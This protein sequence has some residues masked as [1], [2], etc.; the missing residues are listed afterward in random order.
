MIIR[1]RFAP[2]PTGMLHIGGLRTAIFNWLLAKKHQ[3]IFYLRVEDTD[4][5][6]S[7]TKYLDSIKSGLHWLG[8]DWNQDVIFQS[9]NIQRH[10]QI[11]DILLKQGKAYYCYTTEEERKNFKQKNPK[12]KFMSKWR[13]ENFC[14]KNI[15]AVVR[16]KTENDG[17]TTL[18]DQVIGKV[19]IKNSELDD[20][21]L[22][23]SNNTATY[24]LA[25]VIDDHD[26]NITHVIRGNDH[27]TNTFR[28]LQIFKALKWNPPIYAHT[29]LIHDKNGQKMSK[30]LNAINVDEYKKLGFLP[31]A[32]FRYL[33]TLGWSNNGEEVIDIQQVIKTFDLQ[34]IHKSPSQFSL[35]KLRSI[36]QQYINTM[37]DDEIFQKVIAIVGNQII[38]LNQRIRVK[39]SIPLI[40]SRGQTI[41]EL[42]DLSLIFISYPSSIDNESKQ[43]LKSNRVIQ[44]LEK[45]F[46]IFQQETNWKANVIKEKSLNF[47]RERNLKHL[48]VMKILRS[49]VLGVFR[50]PPIYET[51]EVMSQEEVLNRISRIIKSFV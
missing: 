3:G 7:S 48:E 29:P 14:K 38:S 1:T 34:N 46:Y 25:C 26:M 45:I 27:F 47:A 43:L 15:D 42:A 19:S 41:N 30:R 12:K 28:Q 10:I 16:L 44:L 5:V 49:S 9:A 22:L 40:R 32:I 21:V 2:S 36:N 13:E 35:Q 31:E 23:R 24:N 4:Q 8:L 6:R 17:I 51:L 50:T 33:L 11:V 39:H 37:D 18:N 20:M